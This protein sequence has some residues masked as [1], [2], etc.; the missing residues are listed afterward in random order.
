MAE[1]ETTALQAATD[2]IMSDLE[3][4]ETNP[5]SD[6]HLHVPD[7]LAFD[8]DDNW[9]DEDD[10]V[11]PKVVPRLYPRHPPHDGAGNMFLTIADTNGYHFLPVVW[12]MCPAHLEDR[13]LQMLR[14]GLY[15]ATYDNIKTVMSF[16][17]LEHQRLDNLECKTSIYQY[18]QKL[19]RLTCPDS[20]NTAP[21]RYAEFRRVSRQWRNMKYRIWFQVWEDREMK[22]GEMGLFCAACPQPGINLPSDW[23]EDQTRHPCVFIPITPFCSIQNCLF[24]IKLPKKF[25][26]G[27]KFQ[28]R[29]YKAETCG[30]LVDAWR[31]IYDRH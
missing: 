2:I 8:E 21:N 10:Y 29:P 19:R 15:P 16:A 31:R 9:E 5:Q 7:N 28:S 26:G 12:C 25:C 20:P 11:G 14:L 1:A 22:M 4:S 13:D 27:W 30:C 3:H 6:E 23:R 24:K 18:H 17:L